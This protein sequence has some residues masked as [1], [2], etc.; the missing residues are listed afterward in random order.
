MISVRFAPLDRFPE[1]GRGDLPAERSATAFVLLASGV[2][3]NPD[4]VSSVRGTNGARRYAMPFRIMPDLGQV[5]ENRVQPSTKQRCHVLQ[6]RISRSNH[7]N[8]SNHFPPES[9]TGS[10]KSGASAG[11]RDVLAGKARTDDVGIGILRC[12]YVAD[13]RRVGKA[14][15]QDLARVRIGFGDCD[16]LER[17]SPMQA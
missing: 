7:A 17:S 12:R 4:A 6:Q 1:H 16:G 10:G 9:R 15:R 3:N 13:V 11:E 8:G 2:G 5:S 14:K